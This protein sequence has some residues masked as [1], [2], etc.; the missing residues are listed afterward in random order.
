VIN[1]ENLASDTSIF[2]NN[3][4]DPFTGKAHAISVQLEEAEVNLSA[5]IT[6]EMKAKE[7]AL[8][9][10]KVDSLGIDYGG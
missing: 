7:E 5:L 3:I 6:P 9:I 10:Y 1:A 4:I 8:K 2:V